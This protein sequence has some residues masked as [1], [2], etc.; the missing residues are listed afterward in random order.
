[1][2]SVRSH[3]RMVGGATAEHVAWPHDRMSHMVHKLIVTFSTGWPAMSVATID[4]DSINAINT[5]C[6]IEHQTRAFKSNWT[7]NGNI[8]R[9]GLSSYGW[10]RAS[11]SLRFGCRDCVMACLIE[12]IIFAI[13]NLIYYKLSKW[14]PPPIR[15]SVRVCLFRFGAANAMRSP[16]NT[17]DSSDLSWS[18]SA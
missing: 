7:W 18:H 11:R 8:A 16:L 9:F 15:S 3:K 12:M 1:M 4:A 6:E 14:V 2:V 10:I 17:H 5:Q 13:E